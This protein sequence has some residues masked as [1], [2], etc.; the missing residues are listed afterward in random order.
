MAY[1]PETRGYMDP[2]TPWSQQQ[3]VYEAIYPLVSGQ[4]GFIYLWSSDV[5]GINLYTGLRLNCD[6]NEHQPVDALPLPP[7]SSTP[8][9]WLML[10]IQKNT[11]QLIN[12]PC[13]TTTIMML[14]QTNMPFTLLFDIQ[15]LRT[16]VQILSHVR[17]LI[18]ASDTGTRVTRV[19]MYKKALW[20]LLSALAALGPRAMARGP[21]YT[22]RPE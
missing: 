14:L 7:H 12:H 20:P 18:S 3:G 11:I 21:S 17:Y 2:Y 5:Y 4:Y 6:I 19:S 13:H 1:C 22:L 9:T 15:N 10:S 16:K 8:S